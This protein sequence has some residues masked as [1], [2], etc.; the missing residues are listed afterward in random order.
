MAAFPFCPVHH[1]NLWYLELLE[2][3]SEE[4]AS[5]FACVQ[6]HGVDAEECYAPLLARHELSDECEAYDTLELHWCDAS[7][8]DERANAEPAQLL[9]RITR[10]YKLADK[11]HLGQEQ[12]R[13]GHDA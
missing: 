10:Q 12:G 3:L 2:A 6:Q 5:V 1:S 9:R 8:E 7:T 4:L 13:R 11:Y